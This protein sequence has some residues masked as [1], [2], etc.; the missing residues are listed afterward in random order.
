MALQT[1]WDDYMY[2]VNAVEEIRSELPANHTLIEWAPTRRRQP[3][4]HRRSPCEL[5]SVIEHAHQLGLLRE[6]KLTHIIDE[7]STAHRS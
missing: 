1:L 4:L 6:R 7:E 3:P 2:D 5:V